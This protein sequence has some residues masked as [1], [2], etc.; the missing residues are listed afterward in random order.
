M[1]GPAHAAAPGRFICSRCGMGFAADPR[2]WRCDCGSPLDIEFEGSLDPTFGSR[3]P[4]LWR[5][6]EALPLR[7]D[8][9]VTLGEGMTP[10]VEVDLDGRRLLVKLEQL[11]PTGSFK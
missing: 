3:P 10:L 8:S 4:S 5:Y 9:I 7:G 2:R 6:R 11:C 1:S